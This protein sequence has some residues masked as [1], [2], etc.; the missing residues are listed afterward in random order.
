MKKRIRIIKLIFR[1][2]N[3]LVSVWTAALVL[4]TQM[5]YI[6]TKDVVINGRTAWAANTTLWS[7]YLMTL[8][9]VFS[10][11]INTVTILCYCRGTKSANAVSSVGGYISI[12][13]WVVHLVLWTATT[14]AYRMQY[15]T[16]RDLWGW[17]CGY[18]ADAIQE[19]FKQVINFDKWCTV[20][21]S[22]F[23]LN[24]RIPLL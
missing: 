10:V 8:T 7:S 15:N 19:E 17:S 18:G 22:F 12:F 4:Q 14:V 6:S 11:V 3:L 1:L 23:L 2:L 24:D 21:V 20:Q 16:G 9:S 13:L 5:K